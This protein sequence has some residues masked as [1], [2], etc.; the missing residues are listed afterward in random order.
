[1]RHINGRPVIASLIRGAE[2]VQYA[3]A[4]HDGD[5]CGRHNELRA[6]IRTAA[7]LCA[8]HPLGVRGIYQMSHRG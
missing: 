4:Q 6:P 7:R 2:E 5:D 1:V 3:S 8:I